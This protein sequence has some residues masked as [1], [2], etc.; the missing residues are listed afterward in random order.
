MW[1]RKP[2]YSSFIPRSTGGWFVMDTF[3][4]EEDRGHREP[5]IIQQHVERACSVDT[6]G[7]KSSNDERAHIFS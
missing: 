7:G 3:V 5:I 2:V 6:I 4:K 1:D